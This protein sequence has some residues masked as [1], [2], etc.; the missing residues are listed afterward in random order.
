MTIFRYRHDG[1]SS[2]SSTTHFLIW[3]ELDVFY[4]QYKKV[5]SDSN[6]ISRETLIIGLG[7]LGYESNLINEC[8]WLFDENNDALLILKNSY[9]DEYFM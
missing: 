3:L 4:D 1:L 5:L 7:P 8:S 9:W 2:Q 6:G